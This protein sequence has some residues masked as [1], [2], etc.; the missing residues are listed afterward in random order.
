MRSNGSTSLLALASV[1]GL[2]LA[3]A[4]GY[5]LYSKFGCTACVSEEQAAVMVDDHEHTGD[6]C[7]LH[8][9]GKEVAKQEKADGCGSSCDGE[10]KTGGACEAKGE[11][12]SGGKMTACG[13]MLPDLGAV[14]ENGTKAQGCESSCEKACESKGG[15]CTA[16]AGKGTCCG[17]CTKAQANAK[18]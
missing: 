13:V 6:C 14:A 12:K 17:T 5:G 2:T 8:S 10:A 18:P 11:A 16:E 9:A 1:V 3:G 4:L 15:D 7:P